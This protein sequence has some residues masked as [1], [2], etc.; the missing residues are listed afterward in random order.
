[1]SLN[2]EEIMNIV[3]NKTTEDFI[4]SYKRN[5]AFIDE[6][7]QLSNLYDGVSVLSN[8]T[9]FNII[10]DSVKSK[11]ELYEEEIA[12][13]YT[14]YNNVCE[15]HNF[16]SDNQLKIEQYVKEDKIDSFTFDDESNSKSI[17]LFDFNYDSLYN[18]KELLNLHDL[19][20]ALWDKIETLLSKISE[21]EIIKNKMESITRGD[22]LEDE[23]EISKDLIKKYSNLDYDR[24]EDFNEEKEVSDK[25][26]ILNEVERCFKIYSYKVTNLKPSYYTIYVGRNFYGGHYMSYLFVS[27]LYNSDFKDLIESN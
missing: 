6:S 18:G 7:L 14:I 16:L 8:Y 1:M 20:G 17:K 26:Y 25:K 11:V 13:C 3:N 23:D 21:L 15:M 10:R 22:Y 19:K 27:Q 2:K 12:L 5:D 9:V 24:L 4:C